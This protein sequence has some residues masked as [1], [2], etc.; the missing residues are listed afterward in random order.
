MQVDGILSHN[1]KISHSSSPIC[2]GEFI[3]V[4]GQDHLQSRGILTN[5]ASSPPTNGERNHSYHLP[6]LNL[7][8]MGVL[9]I[10]EDKYAIVHPHDNGHLLTSYHGYTS[11]VIS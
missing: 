4:T 7:F 3:F 11:D 6:R 5:E 2:N 1:A 8:I 10:S 9:Y